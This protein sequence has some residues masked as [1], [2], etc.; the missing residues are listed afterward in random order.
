MTTPTT[1]L[2]AA[3]DD[4][5]N[6]PIHGWFELSYANYLVVPR[7][8]LQ[9]MPVEWQ[10]RMVACLEELDAAYVHLDREQ[11][12]GAGYNVQTGTW[13]LVQECDDTQLERAG[14]SIGEIVRDQDGFVIEAHY[15]DQRGDEVQWGERVFVPALV[16]P[17]PHYN[18]GR[19][20]LPPAG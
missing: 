7:A 11:P 18:R 3:P 10:E 4:R 13:H 16:D 2:A 14:V 8:R 17:N 19:T 15:Y 6:G 12:I 5:L 1:T 9:S 20:F